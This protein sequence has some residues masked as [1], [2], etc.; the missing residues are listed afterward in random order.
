MRAELTIDRLG[1]RGDGIVDRPDG[2]LFVPFALPGERVGVEISP[3]GKMADC[4]EIMTP[5]PDRA[6]PVCGHFGECGGCSLQHMARQSY[7]AWKRALVVHALAA[8]GIDNPV[9]PVLPVPLG[10]R[11]RATFSLGRHGSHTVLG[12][13]ARRS[14]A[15]I[16]VE[17]CPILSSEVVAVLPCLEAMLGPL[18]GAK[19]EARI[20]VT[21]TRN[22]LDVT[23]EGMHAAP[24]AMARLA[25]IAEENGIARI[26][27]GDESLELAPP[28]VRFGKADV[29]LPP[30]G[31]L[32]ASP[33]AVAEMTTL[34]QEGTG[35]AK[36]IADLFSGLGTFTFALAERASVDAY[37]ENAEAISALAHAA[38]HT[39]KLK[40]IKTQRRDLFRDPLGWQELK[41]YD[42]IVFDPPRAGAAAQAAQLAK[43]KV[44]RIVAVSCNP[45]TLARDLRILVDDGYRVTRIAPIDQFLYSSHVE[46]VAHLVR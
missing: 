9:E 24:K 38:R 6:D 25:P 35:R 21:G 13:R 12:Y 10:D 11:R 39:L 43:S 30:R 18:M 28:L 2:P 15:T 14:H 41:S 36:R 8:R 5:S 44:K 42:A 3:D 23:V 4:R 33:T 34:V 20:S 19:T 32:Q 29:R 37:E 26:S 1:A 7:L 40:P 16:A 46:V 27:I 22:G 45:G 17:A 31:F